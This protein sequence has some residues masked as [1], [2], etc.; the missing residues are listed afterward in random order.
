MVASTAAEMVAAAKQRIE[1]LSPDQ[2]ES[3]LK[4]GVLLVDIREPEERVSNGFIAGDTH[5][6]RGMLE[7][8]ADPTSPYHRVEFDP[9]QRIILYCAS[10]G[11]SSLAAD[12][13]RDLGYTRVAHLDGGLKA[14]SEAGKPV[15]NV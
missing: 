14:W 3:E 15:E 11:R 8:Y 1:N 6:A 2:V 7:F 9:D 12:M 13:L 5:A 10:C 4:S